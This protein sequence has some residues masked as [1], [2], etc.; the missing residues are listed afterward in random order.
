MIKLPI[1]SKQNISSDFMVITIR[2][3]MNQ[4][5]GWANSKQNGVSVKML[6]KFW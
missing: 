5:E 6:K 2:V 4:Y 3:R 1:I